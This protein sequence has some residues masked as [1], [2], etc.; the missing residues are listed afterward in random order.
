MLDTV[1]KYVTGR[2][3][4]F[5]FTPDAG[6]NRR[7]AVVL[8][9]GLM[10][11][12]SNMFSFGRWLAGQGYHVYVYDYR[13]SQNGIS[14]H[15]LQLRRYLNKVCSELPQDIP[16]NMVT[17]SMGGIIT[18][19]ALAVEQADEIPVLF[20]KER[21]RR[22]VM[23]GPPHGGSDLARFASRYLP[24]SRKLFKPIA[25]LSSAPDAAVHDSPLMAGPE[26]GIIAG[27]YDLQVAVRYTFM[28]GIKD[29]IVLKSEHS[30]MMK[31]PNVRTACLE[32][33]QKG[34]FSPHFQRA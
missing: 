24:F 11:R 14:D 17:H 13:T 27:K 26:V 15:G 18:R 7:E 1:A 31:M 10:R 30:L 22:I 29:H 5:Y 32:F 21:I 6:K 25:E 33:L 8:V 34:E 23:L 3:C 19:F 9:H 4:H 16:V 12:S 20:D 2:K 28:P